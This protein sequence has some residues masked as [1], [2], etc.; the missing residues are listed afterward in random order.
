[1]WTPRSTAEP[2]RIA[3][4][5]LSLLVLGVV[6][7]LV[8][9]LIHPQKLPGPVPVF[10]YIVDDIVHGDMLFNIGMTLWRSVAA[11]FIAMV[12]G[13]G[14]GLWLGRSRGAD[15]AFMPWVLFFQNTPLIVIGAL[16]FI[17]FRSTE[18]TAIFAAVVGK[19][20]NNTIIVRDG[21]RTF[22]PALDEVATLYRLSALARFRDILWPQVVPFVVV[23]ARSGIGVVW[24]IVIVIELF[25]LSSGVGFQIYTHFQLVETTPILGYSIAFSL[26]MLSIELFVLQPLDDYARRWR[27]LAS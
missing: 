25:G 23:A 21:V 13:C 7:E 6:W 24:K 11:F 10:A 3:R 22:D 9:A 12:F 8:V 16:F 2:V 18:W 19:F 1:M 14:L 15:R 26:L 17:W 27:P 20:P 5:A 4:F